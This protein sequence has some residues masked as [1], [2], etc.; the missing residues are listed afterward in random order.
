MNSISCSACH[1]YSKSRVDVGIVRVLVSVPK[2]AV[3]CESCM[4]LQSLKEVVSEGK[5]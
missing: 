2:L 3:A 5:G 1:S 4:G